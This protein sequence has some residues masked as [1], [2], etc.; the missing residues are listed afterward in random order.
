MTHDNTKRTDATVKET[1]R[2]RNNRQ[3][4]NQNNTKGDMYLTANEFIGQ[5]AF[6]EKNTTTSKLNHGRVC[7]RPHPRCERRTGPELSQLE[8]FPHQIA[9]V[10]TGKAPEW[11]SDK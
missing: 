8:T 10:A 4:E 9:G 1:L 11:L 6:V 5:H 7:D 3:T 2:I